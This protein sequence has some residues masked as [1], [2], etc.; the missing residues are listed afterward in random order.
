MVLLCRKICY[1]CSREVIINFLFPSWTSTYKCA[2]DLSCLCVWKGASEVTFLFKKWNSLTISGTRV[3]PLSY[4]TRN[5][6]I[7]SSEYCCMFYILHSPN[8]LKLTPV[9]EPNP[10]L[11]PFSTYM[12]WIHYASCELFENNSHHTKLVLWCI[13]QISSWIELPKDLR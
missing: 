5:V 4:Y 8:V 9:M 1:F 7:I 12:V 13:L 3:V 10:V 11:I 2:G 6:H